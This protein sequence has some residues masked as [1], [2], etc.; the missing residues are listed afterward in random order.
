MSFSQVCRLFDLVA[1]VTLIIMAVW[2]IARPMPK[3]QLVGPIIV[4]SG[5]QMDYVEAAGLKC[6]RKAGQWVC[7]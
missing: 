7:I 3:P 2:V 5:Q 6:R 1:S 4:Q